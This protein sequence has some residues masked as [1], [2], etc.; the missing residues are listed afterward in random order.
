MRRRLGIALVG[1]VVASLVLAGVLSIVLT[2]VADRRNDEAELREQTEALVD[3]FGEVTLVDAGGA[4]ETRAE[5][6]RRLSHT[7]STSLESPVRR[8]TTPMG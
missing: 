6:L 5:R 3:L 8:A 2:S 7:L 4:A 1:M